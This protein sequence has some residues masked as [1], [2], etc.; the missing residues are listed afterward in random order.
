MTDAQILDQ[1]GVIRT[2]ISNRFVFAL[3]GTG[4]ASDAELEFQLTYDR[5]MPDFFVAST[6][7]SSITRNGTTYT[8]IIPKATVNT[9]KTGKAFFTLYLIDTENEQLAAGEVTIESVG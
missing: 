3:D 5:R 4:V 6:T 2:G 7:D 9:F 8:V 1:D